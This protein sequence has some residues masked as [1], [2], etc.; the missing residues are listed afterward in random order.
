MKKLIALAFLLCSSSAIAQSSAPTSVI[1]TPVG[2]MQAALG[3][4]SATSLTVPAGAS[5]AVVCV[6]GAAIRY[7]VDGSTTPTAST[8]MPV[9]SGQ[10]LS[11]SGT[12]AL[13]NF[14]AIQQT[15]TATLDVSYFKY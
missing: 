8:G 15:A 2:T 9:S 4:A 13:A 7:T 3:V 5:Y 6:E 10:C 14:K 1:L 12:V 11:L